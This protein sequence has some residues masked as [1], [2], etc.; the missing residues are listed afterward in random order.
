MERK[1]S[2]DNIVVLLIDM[3]MK[4]IQNDIEKVEI[5]PN[6][7]SVLKF[8]VAKQ[9]PIVVFE[10]LE[11]GI[12]IKEIN[13]VLKKKQTAQVYYLQKKYD[14][15]F[16]NPT[17][18]KILKSFATKTILIMGINAGFC[19]Y[20]TTKTAIKKGY[21]VTTSRDLIAGYKSPKEKSPCPGVSWYKKNTIFF[22][23]HEKI[24]KKIK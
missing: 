22:D 18:S 2:F 1:I 15:A 13:D 16:Y 3:Q 11:N 7:I 19:V 20:E 17:L 14:D 8:C 9:I 4:F 6:Q 12:T 10:Y 23:S 21:Q 24:I 5:I